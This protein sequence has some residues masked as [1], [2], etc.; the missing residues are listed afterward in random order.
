M[1]PKKSIFVSL[2]SVTGI[3]IVGKILGFFKQIVI[4]RFFG[5]TFETDIINLSEGFISNVDYIII[6]TLSTAILTLFVHIKSKDKE[7]ANALITNAMLFFFLSISALTGVLIVL[8]PFISKLLA[9]SF[10]QD[11]TN[12][13]TKYLMILLPCIILISLSSI[14]GGV[15]QSQKRF[16][17]NQIA[18]LVQSVVTIII[19]ILFGQKYGPFVL[20]PSFIFYSVFNFVFLFPLSKREW[21]FSFKYKNPFRNNNFI[22]AIRIMGPLFLA[23]GAIFVNQIVDKII[24]SSMSEGSVSALAYASTLSNFVI[25]I[26]TALTGVM[27]SHIANEIASKNENVAINTAVKFIEFSVAIFI[28]ITIISMVNSIDVV[29]IAYLR[30]KF[31]SDAASLTSAALMGYAL[32]FVFYSIKSITNKILYSYKNTKWPM[33][34]SLIAITMNIILSIILSNFMGILGVALASSI[35]EIVASVINVV[36]L[37][38]LGIHLSFKNSPEVLL[39]WSLVFC[40]SIIVSRSFTFLDLHYTI[41]FILI[42]LITASLCCIVYYSDIHRLF[43]KVF[44]SVKRKSI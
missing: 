44:L 6:N 32:S 18:S 36:A 3:L 27:Y 4:A 38:S 42:V 14:C 24:V 8:S 41:R 13:L 21:K 37:K 7:E 23:Y 22:S 17:P 31:D 16:I 12:T 33:F 43:K 1:N 2:F 11:D 9:P 26:I 34:S 40:T 35:A 25:A 15:L 28:P 20:I 5:A 39:K 19:V 10:S 30:G 29:N